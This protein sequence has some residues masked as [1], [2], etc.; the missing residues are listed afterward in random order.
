MYFEDS[1]LDFIEL[2]Q[3]SVPNS[4]EV[5]TKGNYGPFALILSKAFPGGEIKDIVKIGH[6]IYEYQDMWYD[7]TGKINS[8]YMKENNI[9][10]EDV[11]EIFSYY[12][13]GKA[14]V[15]LRSNYK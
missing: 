10:Y 8:E 5:F 3:R 1:I 15:Y 4:I 12:G 6:R 7:I 2:M 9:K 11:K 13:P 14:M